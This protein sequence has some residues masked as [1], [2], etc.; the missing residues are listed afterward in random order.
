MR[1]LAAFLLLV[2]GPLLLLARRRRERRER[3]SLY[4]GD[5]STVTLERGAPGSERLLAL[6]R[7]AL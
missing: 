2:A 4:Y 3:V 6:A 7:R 5:G 1:R